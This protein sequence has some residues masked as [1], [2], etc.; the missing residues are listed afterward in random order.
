MDD[1]VVPVNLRGPATVARLD[2]VLIARRGKPRAE[3]V[4][5]Q[6]GL[7]N[8]GVVDDELAVRDLARVPAEVPNGGCVLHFVGRHAAPL[9][10]RLSIPEGRSGLIIGMNSSGGNLGLLAA[11]HVLN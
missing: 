2:L 3:A 11:V 10:T 5:P 9:V 6:H 4:E 7:R 8:D 1:A